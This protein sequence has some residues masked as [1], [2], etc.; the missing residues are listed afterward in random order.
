VFNRL[1]TTRSAV[2][3]LALRVAAGAIF[4]VFSFGKFVRRDAE[5]RAFARYGVPWPEVTVTLVGALEFVGGLLLIVGLLTRPAA[6]ALAANM[7]GAVSTGGRVD[8]GIVHLGLAPALLIV[9]LILLRTGAG[10][11]SVDHRLTIDRAEVVD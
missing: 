1:L 8:G 4:F 3:P 5:I 11:R 7:V 9:M 10:A 2:P 6:A